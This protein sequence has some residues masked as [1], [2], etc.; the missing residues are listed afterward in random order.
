[1]TDIA[2][3]AERLMESR[4]GLSGGRSAPRRRV[5]AAEGGCGVTG[6]ACSIPVAGKHIYAPSVQ[7]HNRGNGKGGG[8]AAAGLV[9]EKLGVSRDVLEEDYLVQIALL[10]P[11]AKGEIEREFIAPVFDV[12][13]GGD[14]ETVPD[15]REIEGLVVR[16]PDVSRYFVRVKPGPLEKF[17]AEHGLKDAPP[18]DVEDEF[19]YQNSFRLNVKFYASL[20]EKRAFVL[21]HGRNMCT[22]KIVGYAEQAAQY[23]QL[24]DLEA[25]VWI[26][27]QRYPTKGRVWHPGG[28]H[29]FCGM[30]EAL[31]HNGDFAN[32]YSVCEYLGQ[33]NIRPLFLTDTEVSVLLFD[34]WN[35]LYQYPLEYI[36]EAL[37]PTTERD[38]EHLP[39]EKQEVYRQIQAAHIHASPDGPWFFII[40][41]N[42]PR[43]DRLQLIG[44]TDT[45]MLR[46]QVFAIQEGE[47][48]IGLI[49]SEKQA[50][51][52]T[53][54]SLASDDSRFCSIADRYWNA[55]GGSH[56]DGGAF[57]F[58]IE[59]DGNGDKK[60]VCT[61]KFGRLISA[62]PHQKHADLTVPIVQSERAD[63]EGEEI[64]RLLSEGRSRESYQFC[65]ERMSSW[66]FGD[67]RFVCLRIVRSASRDDRSLAAAIEALTLLN[68]RRYPTGKKKR[69]SVLDIIH[70]SLHEIFGS[71][72][73]IGRG[74]ASRYASIDWETRAEL[75]PPSGGEEV[76]VLNARA[77]PPQ[78]DECDARFIARAYEMGW[79]RFV[80]YGYVGQRFLGCGLGPDTNGVIIDAYDSTGDYLA[81]GIDGMTI[82]VHWNGQDQLGQILHRGKLVVHG[83][84]GQTFMYGAKGGRV[85]VLGN[86]AG[87]PLIN[88]V[89]HPRVV[90]N[91]TC[92]DY[93]AESFMAGDPLRG[94]GFVVLNGIE[95]DDQGQMVE[96]E[97][98]YP[99]GN[100]F[101]LA[102]GGAIYVRDP[103]RRLTDDQLNGGEFTDL[104][105]AD[106]RLVENLLRENEAEFDITVEQLLTV[107]GVTQPPEK[108]YRK[109]RAIKLAVLTELPE[110]SE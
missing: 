4:R 85:F 75:R 9:P 6:F 48:Q 15:Y 81:S 77:F 93:L 61:D 84:V 53:L 13:A 31:V 87:R 110:E 91:G 50:I 37:A 97:T 10:D 96:M 20:G 55:R 58:T 79:K 80:C 94:G 17:A 7:M 100:L 2:L 16:P 74:E 82:N 65:R 19:V 83:D 52:G 104:S 28:A 103:H 70:R 89:G 12:H 76:L 40:G 106:W 68:D 42:D 41:R 43:K 105:P 88:A 71:V 49:C 45:S 29:P 51:D 30:H 23:Y 102:S 47:V 108:V 36:I 35:R 21:S 66:S 98:P 63:A 95:I 64:E 11:S 5:E 101:S 59:P 8:I 69:S 25:H 22:F 44:I 60:L 57:I 3:F 1:M 39:L 109:V 18:R 38:F 86:A 34:L 33:R 26:A 90:I 46:P 14:V 107:D 67:F 72:P 54:R 73:P 24:E 78:G 32:Y 56:T 62:P 27:H 92:L 99:G